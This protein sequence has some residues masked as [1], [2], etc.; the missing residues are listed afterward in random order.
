MSWT[1][2]DD[3]IDAWIGGDVPDDVVKL[4]IW[5][6]KAEREIRRRVPDIQER[7]D[8]EAAEVPPRT[9][10]LES[11]R[12]VVV[13][14][15][16]RIFRN[17]TGTRQKNSTVTTGPFSETVSETVGGNSPGVLEPT[18]DELAKLQ[19]LRATGAFTVSMIPTDSAFSGVRDPLWWVT[20]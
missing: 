10:L 1:T 13:A 19:G 8:A 12:D 16:T 6:D 15:V 3:V 4:Q 14:M 20:N 2:P 18:A 7:I 11:A 17:P 5:L 9:D